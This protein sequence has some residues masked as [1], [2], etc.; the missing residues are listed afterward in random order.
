MFLII[1]EYEAVQVEQTDNFWK[2]VMFFN[3]SF[4]TRKNVEK[5]NVENMYSI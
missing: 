3:E 5:T 1:E 2:Y 4:K